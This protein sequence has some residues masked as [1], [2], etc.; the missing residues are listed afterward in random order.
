MQHF[1]L[2]GKNR[3]LVLLSLN[4]VRSGLI[5]KTNQN[6]VTATMNEDCEIWDFASYQKNCYFDKH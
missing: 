3:N 5:D 2:Q 1:L 4:A 6:M